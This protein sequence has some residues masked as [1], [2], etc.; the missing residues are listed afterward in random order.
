MDTVGAP[1]WA[2]TGRI[3]PVDACVPLLQHRQTTF[4]YALVR[5]LLCITCVTCA[6]VQPDV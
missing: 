2:N 3:A 1:Q 4:N 5:P 6:V